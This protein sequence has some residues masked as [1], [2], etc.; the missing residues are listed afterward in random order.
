MMLI[1]RNRKP[2]QTGSSKTNP[3][4]V[5]RSDSMLFFSLQWFSHSEIILFFSFLSLFWFFWCLCFAA[6]IL[7]SPSSCSSWCV[8]L[9]VS[10]LFIHSFCFTLV[11]SSPLWPLHFLLSQVMFLFPE[12]V[13]LCLIYHFLFCECFFFLSCKFVTSFSLS[14][15]EC[16]PVTVGLSTFWTVDFMDLCVHATQDLC[17]ISLDCFFSTVSL[18]ISSVNSVK[19]PVV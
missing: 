17:C 6:L 3:L 13:H 16:F 8:S 19:P 7:V 12:C 9:P 10:V 15:A 14:S 5:L 1:H 11:C 2:V 4:S 18:I